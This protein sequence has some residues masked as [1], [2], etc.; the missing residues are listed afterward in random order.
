M[1]SPLNI[2]GNSFKLVNSPSS[3]QFLRKSCQRNG[4][5]ITPSIR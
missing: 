5:P 3:S 1:T 2:N 4:L